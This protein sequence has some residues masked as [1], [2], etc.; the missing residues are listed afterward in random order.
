VRR[1]RARGPRLLPR[2]LLVLALLPAGT[3]GAQEPEAAAGGELPLLTLDEAVREALAANP[4]IGIARNAAAIAGNDRSLGNAGFLPSLGLTA[5][6][7]RRPAPVDGVGGASETLDLSTTL[8]YTLFDGFRRGT[9]YRRLGAAEV[10]AGLAAER[11]AESTLASVAVLYYDLVRQQQQIEV[12]RE[13]IAISEERMRIAEQR[14]D[15]GSA[16]ELEVRRAQVDRNADRAALLRQEVAL[17]SRKAALNELLGRDGVARFR[18]VDVIPL[19][20]GL[21]L[22]ALTERALERNRSLLEAGQAREVAA[23]ERRELRSD[24]YPR[25]GLQV[26][27]SMAELS[28]ELGFTPIQPGGVGYGLTLSFNLFDG[29]NRDRRLQ[30]AR[31]REQS[32]A[33]AER[34]ERTRVLTGLGSAHATYRNLLLLS[35]LEAENAELA[36]E[37]VEVALE[38]F[39]LGLST[40]VEL[41]EVQNALAAARSRLVAARFDAKQAEIELLRLSGAL[42]DEGP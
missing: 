40:S 36:R 35:E 4:Q 8:G 22:D 6:Q 2:V 20:G 16:S 3:A 31:L 12:L 42:L 1:T 32:G 41:R 11:V 19:D 10:R 34:Q 27:Y 18:V 23:L 17:T 26:G 38:R 13:S 14:R 9:A 15:V 21:E 39:R 5:Q 30:N 29:F 24:W 7:S 33:L 25:V 37:N 28:R